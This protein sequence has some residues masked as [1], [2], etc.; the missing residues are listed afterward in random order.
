MWSYYGS[1]TNIVDAY[2]S[3]LYDTIIEPFAGAAKYSLKWWDRKIILIEKSKIICNI[4][5]YL[6]HASV[7]DIEKLPHF[8]SP[9]DHLDN[10]TFACKEEKDL[11]GFIVHYGGASPSGAASK[12]KFGPGRSGRN[13]MANFTLQKIAANLHKI[14]HWKIINADY[15]AAEDIAATWFIDPPYKRGGDK[16]PH[17]SK[18][19]DYHL[20]ARWC[21]QRK[22]QTI[23]CENDG[24]DWLPFKPLITQHG[25]R[26]SQR[27]MIYSS[28]PFNYQLNLFDNFE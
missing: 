26:G 20:L 2:P 15:R 21:M 25:L 11:M 24:G 17:S 5:D 23:V 13:N 19:I 18:K 3:P 22:G 14:R 10:F 6:V 9:G 12:V 8:F 4:W 27:E 7:T 1:K 16:Y 28:H